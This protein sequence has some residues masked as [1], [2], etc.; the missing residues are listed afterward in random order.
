MRMTLRVWTLLA[1]APIS[2]C[3]SCRSGAS[4]GATGPT[5]PTDASPD[6][7]TPVALP[8]GAGG[9]GFD[10]LG[11]APGVHKVL[12]PAAATGNLD[13]VDPDTLAVTSIGGFSASPGSYG[14]GHD[15]GT[16]SADE[17]RGLIFAID[18]TSTKLD[19]VDPSAKA[20]VASAKLAG[21]PDYVRWVGPTHEVW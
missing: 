17:G 9:I 5:S 19:V 3:S 20:I 13:L 2:G 14:G 4:P 11:F 1:V 18:R 15:E 8:G 12:A 10:D 16:T 21:S 6:A 7:S